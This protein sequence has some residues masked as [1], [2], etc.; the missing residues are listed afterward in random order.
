MPKLGQYYRRYLKPGRFYEAGSTMMEI[1]V[2]V[3]VLSVGM[4]GAFNLQLNGLK[5]NQ[6]SYVR[7]QAMILATDMAERMRS[8]RAGALNGH[9]NGFDTTGMLP[10]K[11]RCQKST[12]GCDSRQLSDVDKNEWRQQFSTLLQDGQ[13]KDLLPGGSGTIRA[14]APNSFTITINWLILIDSE[15]AENDSSQHDSYQLE[16]TL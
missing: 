8:N 13:R 3:L 1:V 14:I 12:D 6:G 7:A 10:A 5:M 9:Y 16:F 11:P 15:T 2:S 4:L